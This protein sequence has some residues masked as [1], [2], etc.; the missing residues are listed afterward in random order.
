VLIMLLRY[1]T[2]LCLLLP[3]HAR[4]NLDVHPMRIHVDAGKAAGVRVHSQSALPQY[5][6]ATVKRVLHPGTAREQEIDEAAGEA[7]AVAV[8]PSRFALA[9]G[10]SRLVRVIALDPV[11]QETALRVYFEAV[12][13]LED[14]D[15]AEAP[16]A[17]SATVGVSLVWGV[18]VNV[19]PPQG[20]AALEVQG[21]TLRNGGSLRLGV[22]KVEHCVASSCEAHPVERSV[23]P[24]DALPLPFQ[25]RA[26]ARVNVYYRLSR[27]GYREHQQ[28][29][30]PSSDTAA[31]PVD[32]SPELIEDAA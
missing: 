21:N 5:V 3:V 2:A 4:A 1:L 27:D 8:M 31:A 20:R 19:L 7:A 28:T 29:L 9:A 10:G 17:A 11:A 15:V 26:D 22:L 12:P 13:P 23:Y 14:T 16:G 30:R 18:L 24:G 32:E 25:P 6:R